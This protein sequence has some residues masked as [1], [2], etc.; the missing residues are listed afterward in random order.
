MEVSILV[1]ELQKLKGFYVDSFYEIGENRFRFKLSRSGERAE[2]FC[3]LPN[4]LNLTEY[5]EKG[6]QKSNFYI[7]VRKR[8]SGAKIEGI[9]QINDDRIVEMSFVRGGETGGIIFEL[10]AKGNMLVVDGEKKIALVYRSREF[11]D[12]EIRVG[13]R[14][15]APENHSIGVSSISKDA[16]AALLN[17]PRNSSEGLVKALTRGVSLG[18]LYMEN[19]AMLSG[20]NPKARISAVDKAGKEKIAENVSAYASP[21]HNAEFLVYLK[22][23]KPVD[24]AVCSIEKYGQFE[25]RKMET[26]NALLDFYY[27][28]AQSDD[29]GETGNA[30][31]TEGIR[32]SIEKQK[33]ILGGMDAEVAEARSSGEEIF[34]NIGVINS[35]VQTLRENRRMTREELQKLF[36]EVKIIDVD[37]KEKTVTIDI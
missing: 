29:R 9:T 24:Y 12:R 3:L 11:K 32:V 13:S 16:I 19:A 33:E 36:P 5:S 2:L 22:D 18:A 8:I 10:F 37:L 6:E 31:K 23:G 26:L 15:V 28:E 20:L 30:K 17:D 25:K 14:Y 21:V 34:K 35:I 27:H 7:A 4:T 1:G